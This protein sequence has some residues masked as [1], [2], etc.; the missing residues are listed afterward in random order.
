MSAVDSNTSSEIVAAKKVRFFRFSAL[1]PF[2]LITALLVGGYLLFFDRLVKRGLE[3]SF[4]AINGAKVEIGSFDFSLLDTSVKTRGIQWTNA[5]APTKNLFEIGATEF[6]LQPNPL[7]VGKFVVTRMSVSDLRLGTD[8]AQSGA[9]PA[10][11]PKA[12][13]TAPASGGTLESIEAYAKG[14]DYQAIASKIG[15]PEDIPAVRMGKELEAKVQARS[16]LWKQR[17]PT[18][19]NL[20]DLQ[21]TSDE[22]QAIARRKYKLPD[23]LAQLRKDLDTLKN[24]R[25]QVQAKQDVLKQ[26]RQDLQTDLTELRTAYAQVNELREAKLKDLLIDPQGDLFSASNLLSALLGDS[27]VD[28]ARQYLGYYEKFKGYLP[29]QKQAADVKVVQRERAHGTTVD[30]VRAG[31]LPTVYIGQI[32]LSGTSGSSSLS[33]TVLNASS[34]LSYKPLLINV[35]FRDAQ[36]KADVGTLR[37]SM[38]GSKEGLNSNI[39]LTLRQS[40]LQGLSKGVSNQYLAGLDGKAD[41]RAT[42]T[43]TPQALALALRIEGRNVGLRLKPGSVGKDMEGMLSAVLTQIDLLTVDLDYVQEKGPQGARTSTRLR[44]NLEPLLNARLRAYVASQVAKFNGELRARFNAE[45]DQALAPLKQ[46]LDGFDQSGTLSA[47][48]GDADKLDAA[49]AKL[50]AELNQKLKA[51]ENRFK[52]KAKDKLKSLL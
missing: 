38:S 45:V 39:Q 12:S 25:Q 32:D 20:S 19:T 26:A 36:G 33:G 40:P 2:A 18:V 8:R 37:G 49:R 13:D 10:K 16:D 35:D 41:I 5:D 7:S 21:G 15:Q 29:E 3:A 43:D 28:S 22:I 46:Q 17:L 50:E 34:D 14:I 27:L 6:T 42:L 51:E 23:D 52:S 48:L 31:T 44:S 1:I 30:F 9:L 11:E 24:A 4:T 47:A